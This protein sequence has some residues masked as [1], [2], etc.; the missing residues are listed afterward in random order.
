MPHLDMS[1]AMLRERG[2]TVDVDA[3]EKVVL[4]F[5]VPVPKE[6]PPEEVESTVA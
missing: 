1:V 6:Q 2:V 3:N 5:D 4:V